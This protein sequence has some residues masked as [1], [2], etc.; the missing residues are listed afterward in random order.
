[1]TS[2]KEKILTCRIYITNPNESRSSCRIDYIAYS[3]FQVPCFSFYDFGLAGKEH[4]CIHTSKLY[5]HFGTFGIEHVDEHIM[6]FLSVMWMML[7]R[8]RFDECMI[9]SGFGRKIGTCSS[10]RNEN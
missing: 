5:I 4:V 10:I 3:L 1:M 7:L 8:D 9:F 6:I 2:P